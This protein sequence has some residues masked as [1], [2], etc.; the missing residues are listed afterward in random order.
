[1]SGQATHSTE[2]YEQNEKTEQKKRIKKRK[3]A[4]FEKKNF[5]SYRRKKIVIGGTRDSVF[6]LRMMFLLMFRTQYNMYVT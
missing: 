1:M 6:F 3:D 2:H 5:K 4:I